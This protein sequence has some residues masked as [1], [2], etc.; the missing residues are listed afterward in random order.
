[1]P[2]GGVFSPSIGLSLLKAELAA[3]G[4]PSRVVY[5]SIRFAELVGQDFYHRLAAEGHPPISSLAGEW[6]FSRA[7]FGPR[8]GDEAYVDEVLHGRPSGVPHD[9]QEPLSPALVRRILRARQEAERFVDACGDELVRARPAL[10]GF[11]SMFQQHVASLALARRVKQALPGTFVVFGGANCRD[12]LGAETVR[13]FPFVDAAVSGEA[14]LV[15]PEL[16]RRV[17]EGR[18]VTGLPGVRTRDGLATDPAT[19]RLANAPVVPDLDAL[20]DPDHGDYFEQ[21]ESS[22]YGST[23]R[24]SLPVETSRGCWW[25]ERSQCTFCGLDPQAI[26]FRRKSARRALDELARL[27]RR[28][29]GCS[30]EATD[31]VLAPRAL[32]DFVPRLRS[33][34]PRVELFY[35]VKANLRKDELRRLRDSGV[36]C[37]Q[38]GIESLSD[39]VLRLM[40]KGTSAL[41]NIQL[42]KWCKELGIDPGWNLLWGFPGEAPEEYERMADLVPRL[43]HLPPP[44]SAGAI[45]LDRFSPI[46]ADAERLGLVNVRPVPAYRHVYPLPDEAVARL[47]SFFTFD[48]REPRDV[49]GYVARLERRLRAWPR[50]FRA[51][52]LFSVDRNGWLLV[53][54]LRPGRR[55][56]LTALRGVDRLL[57]QACDSARTARGLAESLAAAPGGPLTAE[58]A[59]RRLESLVERGL[60][61]RDA[62]RYLA[63]AIPLGRYSPPPRAVARF[64]DLARALGRKRPGGW[65]VPLDTRGRPP[66][67]ARQPLRSRTPP[68]PGL[69]LAA[70]QFSVSA[71]GEVRVRLSAG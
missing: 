31:C 50:R 51:V 12:V 16:V 35:E 43:A 17:L 36:L 62:S 29:P 7:L 48:D 64:R 23:W 20:P 38:P 66:G 40:R 39:P 21:F 55:A 68:P 56:P 8:A 2:F 37:I 46:F 42:L 22:R 5:F 1:M 4:I 19:G 27:A 30:V 25:G 57:Y 45:R 71:R 18:S 28:H 67:R 3:H 9:R 60:M 44:R 24:P 70:S 15:F 14:D 54:D 47:A 6:I 58:E 59:A 26:A 10:V 41:Q 52:D 61:V 33:L 49:L 53:W 65:V 13:Q 63:L 11:S 34:R 69:R 32:Q